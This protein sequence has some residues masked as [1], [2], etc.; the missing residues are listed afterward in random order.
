MEVT[1]GAQSIGK[2]VATYADILP[3]EICALFGS[4]NHIEIAANGANASAL[5]GV[6]RGARVIISP[7]RDRFRSD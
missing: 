6:E 7:A 3:G 1:A 4:S 2:L 5:L